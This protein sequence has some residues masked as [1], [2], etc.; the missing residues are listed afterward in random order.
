MAHPVRTPAASAL[1]V[2]GVAVTC[3]LVGWWCTGVEHVD[4]FA[5]LPVRAGGWVVLGWSVALLVLGLA[6]V[7]R[8]RRSPAEA[9]AR[10]LLCVVWQVVPTS[11]LLL[12]RVTL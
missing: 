6:V 10:A 12:A 3:G 11:V 1:V 8:T 4:P 2:T 7:W 9:Y 5:R